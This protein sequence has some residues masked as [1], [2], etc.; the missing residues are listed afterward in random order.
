MDVTL[1][2]ILQ[3]SSMFEFYATLEYR[4]F[5]RAAVK[6]A[7]LVLPRNTTMTWHL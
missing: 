1:E 3:G 7:L 5:D 6:R 2:D 4:V